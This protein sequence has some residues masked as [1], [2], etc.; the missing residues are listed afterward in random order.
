MARAVEQ[1]EG[2]DQTLGSS[3]GDERL[4]LV[5][6]GEVPADGQLAGEL[7]QMLQREV[8]PLAP[9]LDPP[10]GFP[11]AEYATTI[12]LALLDRGRP[13]RWRKGPADNLAALNLLSERHLPTP[14]PVRAIAVF[15]LM[16][17]LAVAAVFLTPT[18]NARV[19]E[20][21]ASS[22]VL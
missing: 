3:A 10:E 14:L 11:V 19:R 22:V 2:Y 1:M 13:R 21:N 18:V 5:L 15:A 6:T 9:P 4:P 16:A 7:R 12:G 17:I 20:S 8:L